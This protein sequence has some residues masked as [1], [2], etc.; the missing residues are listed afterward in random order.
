M[1]AVWRHHSMP[2]RRETTSVAAAAHAA[3]AAADDGSNRAV[4]GASTGRGGGA[5]A[6]AGA[7]DA[8]AAAAPQ[9]RI[10]KAC[11]QIGHHHRM[12][13]CPKKATVGSSSS[14][15]Q[16]G[17][18]K[19][20]KTW[21]TVRY[22]TVVPCFETQ[23]HDGIVATVYQPVRDL[24]RVRCCVLLLTLLTQWR[25]QPEFASEAELVARAL[26]PSI[27]KQLLSVD[28]HAKKGK[29]VAASTGTNDYVAEAKSFLTGQMVEHIR[30]CTNARLLE[31]GRAGFLLANE[32]EVF[33]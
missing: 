7:A 29:Q 18:K 22:K 30:E 2:R 24:G 9:P 5:G 4:G 11:G 16:A 27:S 31:A 10:C 15:T 1:A 25:V 21:P 6:G 20:G 17:I 14:A 8:A 26:G 23:E 3:A 28:N 13:V 12:N 33:Q 19:R 32:D